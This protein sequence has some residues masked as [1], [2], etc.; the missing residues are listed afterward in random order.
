MDAPEELL[1]DELLLDEELLEEALLEELLLDEEL[2]EEL[3]DE[4]ELL[5]DELEE[6]PPVLPP[7]AASDMP[8]IRAVTRNINPTF[9]M[10][11]PSLVIVSGLQALCYAPVG[12]FSPA[13]GLESYPCFKSTPNKSRQVV[14]QDML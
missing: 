14:K 5:L 12:S 4:L 9:I 11:L 1:E 2:D 7:Q 10:D 8:H 3:L 6:E 13:D